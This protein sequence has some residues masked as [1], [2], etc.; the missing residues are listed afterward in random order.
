MD[1]TTPGINGQ[2]YFWIGQLLGKADCLE[3]EWLLIS[4]ATFAKR[5]KPTVI[6]I[7]AQPPL[8]YQMDVNS[9]AGVSSLSLEAFHSHFIFLKMISWIT[10]ITSMT[11]IT[12]I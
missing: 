8:S 10:A 7:S 6:G 11:T 3:D 1:R 2:D 9:R 5:A 12:S 4:A